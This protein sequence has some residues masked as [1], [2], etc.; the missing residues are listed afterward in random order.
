MRAPDLLLVVTTL[1][2]RRFSKAF[3]KESSIVD[4][5]I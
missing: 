1:I 5:S 4:L 2:P 3:A